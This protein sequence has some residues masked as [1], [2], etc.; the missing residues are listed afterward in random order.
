MKWVARLT[1]WV[2]PSL[3]CLLAFCRTAGFARV[4][5]RKVIQH[6]ACILQTTN[7]SMVHGY[8][9]RY[10]S[11]LRTSNAMGPLLITPPN[12]PRQSALSPTSACGSWARF[13]PRLPACARTRSQLATLCW[14]GV[15]VGFAVVEGGR[16]WFLW[17]YWGQAL[18]IICFRAAVVASTT[19][20]A[21]T[22]MGLIGKTTHVPAKHC[23]TIASRVSIALA[24]LGC[25]VEFVW[26]NSVSIWFPLVL[27]APRLAQKIAVPRSGFWDEP[28]ATPTQ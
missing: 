21:G 16:P 5:L 17:R 4:E 7:P 1:I 22:M 24:V 20:L 2:G 13:C 19:L 6:G 26:P 25:C 18:P 12:E 27:F 10:V 15:A 23:R 11:Y 14:L 28:S 8:M 9:S 3:E